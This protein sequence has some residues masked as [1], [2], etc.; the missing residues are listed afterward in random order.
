MVKEI[1]LN[2]G[3]VA[4]VDDEDYPVVSRYSWRK[5]SQKG[6]AGTTIKSSN[7]VEHTVYMQHLIL[8][9]STQVDHDNQNHIDNQKENLRKATYQ[10]N[11]WNKGKPRTSRFGKPASQYKGVQRN[12]RAD[13]TVYWRVIIKITAKGVIPAKYI[14][15]GPFASEVE[16][17]RV[18]NQE[19]VNV[20]G[21]WAWL[22]PLP[23][24]ETDNCIAKATA[25]GAA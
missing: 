4:L 17:A 2:T 24:D 11:G 9:T 20:R 18:Y 1:Y 16:A 23:E 6:Y 19:I 12:V 13:G 7:G 10:Q 8:A 5:V 3:E 14:R 25:G 22:N 21:E 15:R